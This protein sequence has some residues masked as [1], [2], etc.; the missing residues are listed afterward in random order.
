MIL[1]LVLKLQVASKLLGWQVKVI[2]LS[3]VLC[4]SLPEVTGRKILN[5]KLSLQEFY[6]LTLDFHLAFYRTLLYLLL[7][8]G[9]ET[10][11]FNIPCFSLPVIPK[12]KGTL[13]SNHCRI[14]NKCLLNEWSNEHHQGKWIFWIHLGTWTLGEW[15]FVDIFKQ[16]VVE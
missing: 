16:P 13:I 4:S 8:Q 11:I 14:I 10:C 3:T 7:P 2:G 9:S 15:I 12:Y 5:I 1:Q 6:W